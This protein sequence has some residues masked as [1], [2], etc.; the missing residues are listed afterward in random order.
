MTTYLRQKFKTN[1][2]SALAESFSVN[3]PDDYFIF[4]G[5][6]HQWPDND[7][8]PE[9]V[10]SFDEEIEAWQNMIAMGKLNSSNVIVGAKRYDWTYN[11][12]FDQYDNSIDL[13]EE[14][15][16]KKYYC[17]TDDLNVYK[18]LSNNYGS[19][20]LY[21]PT[22]VTPEEEITQ[23]GYIWKFM[24]K[25]REEMHDFLMEQFIPIEK[26]TNII[27]SDDRSL[28][29]NVKISSV[30]G[31]IENIVVYQL[32]G[33]Y[34]IA[35]VD[36][37]VGGGEQKHTILQVITTTQFKLAPLSDLSRITGTYDDFYE[38]YVSEGPGAGQKAVISNYTVSSTNSSDITVDVATPLIGLSA[39]SVYRIY[40]RIK[41]TGDGQNASAI[42]VMN[43]NKLITD[44]KIINSGSNYHFASVDVYRKNASYSN[45]TLAKAIISPLF[46]HGFDALSEFGSNMMLINVPLNTRDE[47]LINDNLKNLLTNEYRQIGI[48]KNAYENDPDNL[49]LLGSSE[50][51]STIMEIESLNY[52]SDITFYPDS[53]YCTGGGCLGSLL[54]LIDSI[55]SQGE[56]SNPS[57]ARGVIQSVTFAGSD[58]PGAF[59]LTIANTNGRFLTSAE[60]NY[61]LVVGSQTIS[62]SITGILAEGSFTTNTFSINDFILGTETGSTAKVVSWIANP[63]GT[64]GTLKINDIKGKFNSSYFSKSTGTTVLVRGENV[65]G[66]SGVN[67]TTGQLNNNFSKVGI[68]KSVYPEI[69]DTKIFYKVT[70]TLTIT[71]QSGSFSSDLFRINDIIANGTD[72]T[73]TNYAQA[74]VIG[75]TPPTNI[76]DS[77][78]A[79]LEINGINGNFAVNDILY[80]VSGTNITNARITEIDEPEVLSYYGDVLYIQNV[81]PISTSDDTEEQ[82]KVLIT[83]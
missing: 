13:Y 15:L 47:A 4:V 19:P 6:T 72:D 1:L 73:A 2:A 80:F 60:S 16:E 10:D 25:V 77:T 64:S 20:S 78:T 17:I 81:Q 37:E 23:D 27:Y 11:T 40:P 5:R 34:P 48:L 59:I 76:T 38:L 55:I 49:V 67:S 71:P 39:Q 22:S 65:V 31:S 62:S 83:F 35:I 66:Y 57:Q 7:N 46:G 36:D 56:D 21:K 61:Q 30:P 63:F 51:Y 26:L 28:Q 3:S 44:I 54:G 74:R 52:T 32:G 18:C 14:G 45:K 9:A 82:I 29:N 53:D 12:V 70:T 33:S 58:K 75:Y 42:P 69:N 68:I 8:P 50:E 24:F 41:I 79:K 43:S